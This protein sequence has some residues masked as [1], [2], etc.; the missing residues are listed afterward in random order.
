MDDYER[1][2]IEVAR[3]IA[4]DLLMESPTYNVTKEEHIRLVESN[5]LLRI[6]QELN[7]CL[8]GKDKD[9]G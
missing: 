8:K 3:E 5:N 1:E 7:A 2:C 9:N 6:V 4:E